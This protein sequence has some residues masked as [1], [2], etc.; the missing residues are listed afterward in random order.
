VVSLTKSA[1]PC[2]IFV[3]SKFKQILDYFFVKLLGITKL[4]PWWSQITYLFSQRT[5][6]PSCFLIGMV[7]WQKYENAFSNL[8]YKIISFDWFPLWLSKV[9][10]LSFIK[11]SMFFFG[12]IKNLSPQS[13]WEIMCLSTSFIIVGRNKNYIGWWYY[14]KE[15]KGLVD[16][17]ILIENKLNKHWSINISQPLNIDFWYVHW[18]KFSSVPPK[19]HDEVETIS[20]AIFNSILYFEIW[21]LDTIYQ[22]ISISFIVIMLMVNKIS[23]KYKRR[24]QKGDEVTNFFN[25]P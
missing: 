13:I 3:K 12:K 11:K 4:N 15:R 24:I 9:S 5:F 20:N 2:S 6:S 17:T 10:N 14:H 25:T 18:S 1:C 8:Y 22:E 16:L 21:S 7:N 19:G 23:K